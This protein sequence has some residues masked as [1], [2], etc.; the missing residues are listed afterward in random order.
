M[1]GEQ[2]TI[3]RANCNGQLVLTVRDERLL[4]RI[5]RT[6][7]S[8]TLAQITTQLNDDAS[9]TVS[10]RT[11]QRS[12]HRMDFGSRRPTRLP[13]VIAHHTIGLHVLPGQNNTETGV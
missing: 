8:Q 4:R 6:H 1:D 7:R 12:L 10:K 11:V 5:V 9:R 2:K 3:D 13:L